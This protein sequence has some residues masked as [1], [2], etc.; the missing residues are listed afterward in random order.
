MT[1]IGCF[2]PREAECGVSFRKI[3]SNRSTAFSYEI[4]ET[5]GLFKGLSTVFQVESR[6]FLYNLQKLGGGGFF[7]K[8][9]VVEMIFLGKTL[10]ISQFLWHN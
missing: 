2:C 3:F 6:L 4:R 1:T 9:V 10:D 7:K 8:F 5:M